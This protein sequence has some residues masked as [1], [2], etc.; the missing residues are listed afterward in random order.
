MLRES[1]KCDL[2]G[3]TLETKVKSDE[4]QLLFLGIL[5]ADIYT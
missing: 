5:I 2:V 4:I 3:K 1:L